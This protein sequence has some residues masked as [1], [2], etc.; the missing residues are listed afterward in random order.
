MYVLLVEFAK[1]KRSS[2]YSENRGIQHCSL[3]PKVRELMKVKERTFKLTKNGPYQLELRR[4]EK[5][6]GLKDKSDNKTR[7]INNQNAHLNG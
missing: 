1:I 5:I 2:R 6:I 7:V 4:E 3:H